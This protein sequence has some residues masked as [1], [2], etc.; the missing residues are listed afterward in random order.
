M[1]F[2]FFLFLNHNASTIVMFEQPRLILSLKV[3]SYNK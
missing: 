1:F 2:C 3:Q